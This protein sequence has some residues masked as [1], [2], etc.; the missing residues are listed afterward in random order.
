MPL[1][2]TR[3]SRTLSLATALLFVAAMGCDS[4]VPL[5]QV[6]GKITY[7]GQPIPYAEIEFQPISRGKSSIGFSDKDGNYY[8][9]YTL[10]RKGALVGKHMVSVALRS[11]TGPAPI[12]IPQK[13]GAKSEVE[14]EVQAGTN[15]YDIE[16][17]S[18]E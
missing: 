9:Q 16:I 14:F 10:N 11:H 15:E 17:K 5:G 3:C 18:M 7:D 8:M 13:Y 1:H 2:A 12:E 4:G 6:S